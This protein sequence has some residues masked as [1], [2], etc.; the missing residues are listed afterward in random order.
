MQRPEYF[1]MES[2]WENGG[3]QLKLWSKDGV[4][5]IPRPFAPYCYVPYAATGREAKLKDAIHH[6]PAYRRE[7]QNPADVNDYAHA[8]NTTWEADVPYV[9]QVM[10]DLDWKIGT[11]PKAYVDI[12]VDDSHG[13][14]KAEK[15]PV[16]CIG[17][18]FDDGREVY[19]TGDEDKM[20]DDF[21]DLMKNVGMIITYN[22]G[23]DVWESRSF[24]LP[25]LS[26][27]YKKGKEPIYQ[28]DKA[29]RHCAFIDLY[30]VYK[31][32][33]GRVG[34][35]L[36]GGYSLENVCQHELSKGKV[37]HTEKFS[38]MSPEKL[39]EYNMQDIRLLKELD[40]KFSFTDLSIDMARLTNLC[41]VSWRKNHKWHELKPMI[42]VDQLV[43]KECRDTGVVF[44]NRSYE[45]SKTITGALVVEPKVGM[46]KGVQNLD[47]KQMY[48][49]IMINE[50]ISPDKKRCLIPN[51]LVRLKERRAELKARYNETKSK[52]DYVTQYNYKVL[53]NTIYGAFQNPS[54]RI[55]DRNL[56]QFITKKGQD[57]IKK[58]ISVAADMGYDTIYSDTDSIFIQ[59]T[60]ED[61]QD[62]CDIFNLKIKPYELGLG[63]YYTSILFVG[64]EDGG[65]KKRYAGLVDDGALKISGLEAIKRNYT[66]ISRETQIMMLYKLL[67]GESVENCKKCVRN[68]HY[69]MYAGTYDKWLVI[70]TGVKPLA[71]YN[72]KTR[73]DGTLS[74]LPPHAR[75]AKMAMDMG[76][77]NTYDISFIHTKDD[78]APV[79]DGEPFPADIDYEWYYIRQIQAPL[80][81]LFNSIAIQNGTY[82]NVIKKRKTTANKS[83]LDF[84]SS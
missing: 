8:G 68:L 19:L 67:G 20:L 50:R 17:I 38:E 7:F 59:C 54:S 28:F 60:Q 3:H 4:T 23:T 37:K 62:L 16:I 69:A 12:E 57:I 40:E 1:Y 58:T 51:I 6:E 65:T 55:Y 29:L 64:T 15:D 22:G 52:Q 46:H 5:V 27:R 71:E 48:P 80:D 75:A 44:R 81:Q 78:V 49:S 41:L 25:Y 33:M 70:T 77:Q 83:M 47:V 35:S 10:L 14:P 24:D 36:A 72:V 76:Y 9:R 2:T 18:I 74:K 31:H 21:L 43:L 26:K 39:K 53:A 63:E 66:V 34:K 11:V 73:K 42:M 30:Q 79:I 61:A 32:E 56:A 84:V 45:K 13:I 82:R